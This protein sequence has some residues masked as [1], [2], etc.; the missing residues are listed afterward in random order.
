M[1]ILSDY[2]LSCKEDSDFF[3]VERRETCICP[4]CQTEL[5]H[6]DFRSRFMRL[7]GGERKCLRIERLQCTNDG[8]RRLHRALPDCLAPY[9]H[10]ATEVIS[11]VLDEVIT[12]DD[13]EA[14]DYPCETTMYRWKLWLMANYLRM[15]GFLRS[16]GYRLLGL[17]E[18]LLTS[19]VSLLEKVRTMNNCWLEAIL[20]M[21][22]NSGG[23]LVPLG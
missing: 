17:G 10:Y 14:E 8:C 12:P 6:R 16:I 1:I 22:Y 20:R 18:E 3:Y 19:E 9:K 23:F 13:T 21:I 15:E 2:T 4:S 5:R 7:E 11:G